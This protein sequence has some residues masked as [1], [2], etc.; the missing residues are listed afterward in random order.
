MRIPNH[1]GIIPDGNRRWAKKAG[2]S[3]E[4]G[5]DYGLKPG[6]E[7][8]KLCREFGIKEITY[9]GFTT[10]N[11]K[12]PAV[13]I[14]AFK[15]ACVDAVK[16]LSR[17]DAELLV[18]GN[19]KSP[20]FPEE[21]KPY[22]IRR[23][24]GNGGI[25]VNFLVNYGWHWD[26]N[27]LLKSENNDRVSKKNLMNL[28]C[29]CDISRIDLIIRWGGRRRLSG[30]LPVQSVYSDFYVVDDL[31]PDFKP[32]HFYDALKWYSKQDITLGG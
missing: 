17:E 3:K 12:R 21:L 27:N 10:D 1:I 20:I 11:T 5:Y 9:Y 32:N 13:Q 22:T 30:F 24:F 14:E 28:L 2:M 26:L 23:K 29:S 7:L 19:Y 18:I 31:W 25:K 8:F 4:K 15:K 16:M 6:L